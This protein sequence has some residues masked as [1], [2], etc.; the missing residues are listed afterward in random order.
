MSNLKQFLRL[1]DNSYNH[2]YK[3][4]RRANTR[5]ESYKVMGL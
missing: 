3:A 5:L 2:Q 4:E 1:E